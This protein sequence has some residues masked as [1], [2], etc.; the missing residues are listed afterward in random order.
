VNSAVQGNVFAVQHGALY[1]WTYRGD[2]DYRIRPMEA[3]PAELSQGL[4]RRFPSRLLAVRYEVVDMVGRARELGELSDW[5]AGQARVAVRAIHAVGGQGKTRLASRFARDLAASGWAVTQACHRL[6]AGLGDGDIG[7][8]SAETSGSGLLVVVDYADRWPAA[9]LQSLLNVHVRL[10]GRIRILL[11]ARGLRGWWATPREALFD[12]GFEQTDDVELSPLSVGLA[13]EGSDRVSAFRSAAAAFTRYLGLEGP[14]TAKIPHDPS[15]LSGHA[16]TLH[17][18][19]LVAVHAELR[20]I[21]PP[22]GDAALSTYL[23]HHERQGWEELQKAHRIRSTARHI[24]HAS[25]VAALTQRLPYREGIEVVQ[26]TGIV[27]SQSEADQL[28]LDH[29]VAYP[30]AE[31]GWVLEPLTPDRLAEDY[32]ALC[33]PP[34]AGS[35]RADLDLSDPWAVGAVTRLLAWAGPNEAGDP[36]LP[37]HARPAVTVL[38]EASARWPHLLDRVLWPLLDENRFLVT[39]SGGATVARLAWLARSDLGRLTFIYQQLPAG[40]NIDFD[41]AAALV[42]ERRVELL[43]AADHDPWDRAGLL[44]DLGFRYANAGRR[45][46]ALAPMEE[47]VAIYRRLADAQTGDPAAY[48]P[49]LAGSL[50]NL[51][52]ILSQAGRRTEALAPTEEAVTIYQGLADPNSGDP[53]AYLPDLAGS[54][55]NLGSILSQAGRRAEALAPTEEA[56]TIY[57]GLADPNSG[58]PAAYL[59]DLAGSLNNLG[60]RLSEAGRRA[61]ALAPTEEAVAIYRRLADAQTGDPAAYLPDLAGSLNNLGSRL[62]EAGRRAEALAPT[63][64][65]VA[66]RRR[67]ADP[68]GGNPAAYLPDLAGSLNN[69]GVRFLEAGRRTEALAPTAEAVAIRRR[70][71]DPDGGNPAAYLPS[72]ATSLNNLGSILSQAG[73]RT[74]ALAPTEEAVA[75]RRRLADPDSGNPAA[76]LPSLATALN[77][78]GIRLSHAGRRPEALAPTEE[79]VAIYRGLANP[80]SGNPAA[81]LPDLAGSLNNLGVRILEAGRRAEALAPTEE[82]IA[83]RRRLADSDSGNP[84]AHLPDLA[85]ALN[86]LGSILSRAGRQAEALAPTEEAVAIR[87]QLA[88]PNSGNPA[89]HLPALATSLKNLGSRLSEVGRQGEALAP[90]EE[91]VTIYRELADP[92]SGNPAAYLPNLAS[93][94]YNLGNRLSEVGR[95]VEAVAPA[96]EALMIYRGLAEEQPESFG[97]AIDLAVTL[98][99]QL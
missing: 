20:G 71:A 70:L 73:R 51:G 12:A 41:Q 83:I 65:A 52:S 50:N 79:A 22:Q 91:A 46:E 10:G 44:A 48:L 17:M 59:P 7:S 68:D 11:L 6:H 31:S 94:L 28:L 92:N 4:A 72:L 53:A 58:D 39:A 85:T 67:L 54:L 15:V 1:Q 18:A 9:D 36:S 21:D 77:N 13:H 88:D 32:I 47:A 42:A 56:V 2:P 8:V 37:G 74:E 19:A 78:L 87:R 38:A 40:R 96:Q 97:E 60:S 99:S 82:A 24:G 84:A 14:S 30:V 63:E 66:I 26:E 3:K 90:T 23:L 43:L 16:L 55:N 27:A 25:L 80:N 33:V 5:A 64:E 81:Y 75:I 45:A 35:G 29:A 76:Y 86:N 57:Q 34:S 49:D 95:Q 93:S 61:E 69:L 62:S 98:L 89:A